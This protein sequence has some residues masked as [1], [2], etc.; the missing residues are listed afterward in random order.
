MQLKKKLQLA[1]FFISVLLLAACGGGETKPPPV[2]PAPKPAPKPVTPEVKL[3]TGT[4][5][6]P[7]IKLMPPVVKYRSR[8]IETFTFTGNTL[9]HI[10]QYYYF[11]SSSKQ[12]KVCTAF[13][14]LYSEE[15]TA[16]VVSGKTVSPGTSTSHTKINV[17]RTKLRVR[18]DTELYM[19]GFNTSDVAGNGGLPKGGWTLNQWRDVTAHVGTRVPYKIGVVLPNIFRVS[20]RKI[21]GKTQTIL[22]WGNTQ[23]NLDRD[24]RPLTLEN[25]PAVR[26]SEN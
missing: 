20:S 4:W 12:P 5:Q 22:S 7:C 23:G 3:L 10:I 25:N 2:T 14:K 15:Y 16:K 26:Q 21:N 1:C 9:K 11:S 17:T 19:T 8:A 6:G 13:D 18:V 24:N